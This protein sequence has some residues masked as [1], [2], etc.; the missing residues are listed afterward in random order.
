MVDE[1]STSTWVIQGATPTKKN[2]PRIVRPKTRRRFVSCGSMP[3]VLATRTEAKVKVIPTERYL[4]WERHAI[5]QLRAQ[6]PAGWRPL[7]GSEGGYNVGVVFYVSD[8]RKRDLTNL[9]SA[10]MD[11]LVRGG[12]LADDDW[13]V[14]RAH[15]GSGVRLC[16]AG[17]ERAEVAVRSYGAI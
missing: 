12:V 5:L 8:R 15:D 11:A 7:T 13:T 3:L 14:V 4:A 16:P 1:R 10:A 6:A 9:L 17:Q 2:S